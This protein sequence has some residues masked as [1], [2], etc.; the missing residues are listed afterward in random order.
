MSPEMNDPLLNGTSTQDI[1]KEYMPKTNPEKTRQK[2]K[3]GSRYFPPDLLFFVKLRRLLGS[4]SA[5]K[6][7]PSSGCSALASAVIRES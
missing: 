7:S 1:V 3:N 2:K 4:D 6:K 5:R